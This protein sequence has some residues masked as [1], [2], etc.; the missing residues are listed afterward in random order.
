[1]LSI[2]LRRKL[3]SPL[4]RQT[5]VMLILQ[6]I[7]LPLIPSLV[8]LSPASPILFLTKVTDCI[9]S[10][11]QKDHT[12]GQNN[13]VLSFTYTKDGSVS[14]LTITVYRMPEVKINAVRKSVESLEVSFSPEPAA[15]VTS[16][17]WE[18]G[19]G[20]TASQISTTHVYSNAGDYKITLESKMLSVRQKRRL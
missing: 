2:F 17:V 10:Y 15:S 19:E 3:L 6:N 14:D 1:M 5:I 8:R 18:F 16:A 13:I 7:F 4:R 11:H 9:L 20:A 12:E